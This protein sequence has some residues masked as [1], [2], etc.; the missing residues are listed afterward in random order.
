MA[1]F[2]VIDEAVFARNSERAQR[3]RTPRA[4]RA[5]F[6]GRRKRLIVEL[7]TGIEFSF[8]PAKTYGLQD[9][10]ELDLRDV[11]IEGAGGALHFPHLDVDLSVAR[12]LEGFLGPLD[13]AR[14]DARASASRE[15]GKLGGRPK[16]AAADAA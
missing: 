7:D 16:R 15:N 5:R 9:A 4:I 13:W 3:S 12:L 2:K 14:R 6:D 8:E 1:E 10:S 11:M